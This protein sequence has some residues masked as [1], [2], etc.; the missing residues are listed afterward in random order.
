[1]RI[2]AGRPVTIGIKGFDNAW[3]SAGADLMTTIG[4]LVEPISSRG[5][6]SVTGNVTF[7]P[8]E[9]RNYV[10]TG[11][12]GKERSSIWIEDESTGHAVT[13]RIP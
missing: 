6:E 11:R 7:T 13:E 3:P 1:L 9:G 12:L 2:P 10:V 5:G 4:E 8:R